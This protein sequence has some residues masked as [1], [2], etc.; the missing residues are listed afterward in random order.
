MIV[1]G[2]DHSIVDVC[3]FEGVSLIKFEIFCVY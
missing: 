1:R 3:V 2:V